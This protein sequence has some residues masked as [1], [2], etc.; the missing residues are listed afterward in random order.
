[1]RALY[2]Y[3]M[4]RDPVRADN[5]PHELLFPFNVRALVGVWKARYFEPGVFKPDPARDAQW[6]RGAYLVEGLGHCGA[7]HTPRNALGAE[8]KDQPF[9]GGEAEGWHAPALNADSPK[10]VLIQRLFAR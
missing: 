3:V 5:R 8:K 4:T 2:A 1:M 10:V 9:A 7:C 6:N